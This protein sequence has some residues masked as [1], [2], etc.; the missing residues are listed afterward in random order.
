MQILFLPIIRICKINSEPTILSVLHMIK[1]NEF[2][3]TF[4]RYDIN[5][6]EMNF[7]WKF[8]KHHLSNAVFRLLSFILIDI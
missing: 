3:N 1:N 6:F 5:F 4:L 8:T 7:M 2:L